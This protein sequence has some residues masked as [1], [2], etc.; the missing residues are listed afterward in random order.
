MINKTS[1]L[2]FVL[3]TSITTSLL[4]QEYK[5]GIANWQN[6]DFVEDGVHGLSTEKAYRTLLKNKQG[7]TVIVAVI[8]GGVQTDHEDLKDVMWVNQGEVAGNGIDDDGNGYIDDIHGWNFLGN[9]DGENVR[10]DNLELVRLLRELQPKYISVLPSTPL[11]EKEKRAFNEYQKM[12]TDYMAKL[13]QARRGELNYG[14]LK[15]VIDSI[16]VSIGEPTPTAAQFRNYKAKNKNESRALRIVQSEVEE[17][18]FEKFYEE[19]DEAFEYY[20]NQLKY[21]LNMDFDS[22][23]IVGDNYEDSSERIYGNADIEGPDGKHGTHVAGIIGAV[24]NNSIGMNGVADHVLIMGVRA[25]PDGDERDKDVAN[26]IRYAADNGAKVINMSFGKAYVKDK[27]VVDDAVQYAMEKDVL[28]IH[29]AGNDNKDND[30]ISSYPNPIYVDS[31][32]FN[33]GKGEAWIEVGATSWDENDLI[34]SF[35]NYGKQTVDLFAPGVDIYSTVP[36]SEY[37]ELSGTSMAAPTVAGLAAIIRSYYPRFTAVEVKDIILRSV[38][39]IDN[40][41]KI[42]QDNTNKRVYLSDISIT[43]GIANAYKAIELA[44]KLYK[45]K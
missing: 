23:H 32:G 9:A 26:A 15:E 39:K 8:D 24:R 43:G 40:K 38:V 5:A 31:L 35:S 19:L 16:V 21:H 37:D 14:M 25:V 28:L 17:K 42:R 4:A 27:Q 45:D 13:K 29:A 1:I 3:L 6:L 34:A 18:G 12:T 2:F 11:D 22:R 20:S 36:D 33:Q 30:E 10:Y 44:D 7:E 41:V